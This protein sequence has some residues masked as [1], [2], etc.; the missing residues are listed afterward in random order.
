EEVPAVP[1]YHTLKDWIAAVENTQPGLR[2]LVSDEVQPGLYLAVFNMGNDC[3]AICEFDSVKQS[4]TA[5]F[6]YNL[7]DA[8][9]HELLDLAR[10]KQMNGNDL[11]KDFLIRTPDGSMTYRF[12]WGFPYALP[13]HY[14]GKA[15]I[16]VRYKNHSYEYPFTIEAPKG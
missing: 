13:N 6:S 10:T 16:A 1:Q 3:L 8:S 11:S 12:S 7:T 15:K 2:L 14:S 5:G 4:T 9:G